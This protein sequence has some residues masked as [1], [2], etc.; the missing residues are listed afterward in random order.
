VSGS[1]RRLGRN[2]HAFRSETSQTRAAT[3][4]NVIAVG[5]G[6]IP[7]LLMGGGVRGLAPPKF[8]QEGRA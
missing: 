5:G 8:G 3:A 1:G 6:F 4:G 2:R 7:T